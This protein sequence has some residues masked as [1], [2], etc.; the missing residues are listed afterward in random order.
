MG[1]RGRVA[2]VAMSPDGR[3]IASGGVDGTIRLWPMPDLARTPLNALPH[4][5][6]L[7]RL[8]AL[9]NLRVIRDP[10]NPEGYLVR[11]DSFPGWETPR[12]GKPG[13]PAPTAHA[14][15]HTS[16]TFSP[17]F[18][19]DFEPR[20]IDCVPEHSTEGALHEA[21]IQARS[22]RGAAV[23]AL[24]ASQLAFAQVDWSWEEVCVPAPRELGLHRHQA[25]DVVFDGTTYHMFLNGGQ[26]FLPWDSPWHVGHWTWNALTQKWD[27]DPANPVLSPG[28]RP[29]GR[30]HHLRPG[31]AVRRRR[32]QDVVRRD[33][34][35]S[36]PRTRSG[37]ATSPTA[38]TGP[39]TRTTRC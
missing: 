20:R 1:H 13:R 8:R 39:S 2:A 11:A 3:W 38:A 9:T 26:T 35:L 34:R 29:V 15:P 16:R 33:G 21:D 5:E 7:A 25:G 36:P 23:L 18:L 32:V 10:D 12:A 37:Y 27:P 31:R 24:G 22:D 6:L 28:A 14:G 30:L 19:H 4:P 17:R